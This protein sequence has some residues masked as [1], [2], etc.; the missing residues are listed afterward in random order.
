MMPEKSSLKF[1]A[2]KELGVDQWE[3]DDFFP[4]WKED[5]AGTVRTKA[6]AKKKKGSSSLSCN[7]G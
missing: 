7:V 3:L 5:D 4:N 2:K 6:G 1:L